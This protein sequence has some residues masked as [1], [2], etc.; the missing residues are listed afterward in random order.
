MSSGKEVK[1]FHFENEGG[2]DPNYCSQLG[3]IDDTLGIIEE[4]IILK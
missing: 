1:F 4:E 2:P 3:R